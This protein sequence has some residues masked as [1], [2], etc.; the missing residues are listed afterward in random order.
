MARVVAW[1]VGFQDIRPHSSE[2]TCFTQAISGIVGEPLLHLS[3]FGSKDRQSAP[4]SSQ[5][6]QLDYENAQE[7]VRVLVK[8]FGDR[9]LIV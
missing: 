6:L 5:S 7:L 8:V 2:V 3:T 1:E 9:V 4:K